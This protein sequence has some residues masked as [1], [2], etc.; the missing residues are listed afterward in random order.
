M[1]QTTV[2]VRDVEWL[3]ADEVGAALDVSP[4]TVRRLLMAREITYHRIGG[5]LRVAREDLDEFLTRTRV[6]ARP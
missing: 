6:A 5:Q 4:R 3:G 2:N 1:T